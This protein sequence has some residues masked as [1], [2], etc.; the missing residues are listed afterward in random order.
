MADADRSSRLPSANCLTETLGRP[1]VISSLPGGDGA[2][3]AAELMRAAAHLQALLNREIAASLA[4]R[5]VRDQLTGFGLDVLGAGGIP[6]LITELG[7][8]AQ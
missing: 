2:V 3:V 1:V 4:D 6:S 5:S 8:E 7:I